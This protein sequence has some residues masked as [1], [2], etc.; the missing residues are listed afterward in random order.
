MKTRPTQHYQAGTAVL[1]YVHPG[2]DGPAC[3]ASWQ[4]VVDK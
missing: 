3:E 4:V 1:L 2:W